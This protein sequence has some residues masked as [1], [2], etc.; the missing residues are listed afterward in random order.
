M[1]PLGEANCPR[2]ET[3]GC[4]DL[5]YSMRRPGDRMICTPDDPVSLTAAGLMSIS[6]KQRG[7][8]FQ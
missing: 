1:G 2:F 8:Q 3:A 6:L 7:G 4:I 5:P